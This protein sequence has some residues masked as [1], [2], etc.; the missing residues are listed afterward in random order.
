MRKT[1]KLTPEE[2]KELVAGA[3]KAYSDIFTSEY[4]EKV[5]QELNEIREKRTAKE[6]Q[7][8]KRD[9]KALSFL[10]R[11]RCHSKSRVALPCGTDAAPVLGH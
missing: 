9:G 8:R 1:S 5:Q 2:G 11:D 7:R 6:N 4:L 10:S 3:R